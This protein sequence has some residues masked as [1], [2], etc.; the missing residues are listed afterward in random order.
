MFCLWYF[1]TCKRLFHFTTH[2][3]QI[4]IHYQAHAKLDEED[5][6]IDV[7]ESDGGENDQVEKVIR[8]IH[9]MIIFFF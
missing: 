2:R 9:S 7:I 8:G 4:K 3:S 5:V 1:V 6:N